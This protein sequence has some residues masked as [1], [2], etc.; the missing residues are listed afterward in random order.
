MQ[1]DND[2]LMKLYEKIL[3]IR[4]FEERVYKLILEGFVLGS[5]HLSIGEEASAVGTISALEKEDYILPTHR[6]HA[7]HL[8]KGADPLRLMAELAGKETGYCGGVSGSIHIFDRENHNLGSNGI[9][10]AQF[11]I[12]IGAGFAIKYKKLNNCVVCF[13]GD[14]ATNQGWFYELLNFA[15]LWSLPVIIVVVN[16]L[17]GM[18][19]PYEKTSLAPISKKPEV[20]KIK[21]DTV[22]GNDVESVYLKMNDIVKYVKKEKKPALLECFTYRWSGHSAHDK[23]PYRSGNE[24]ASWKKRDPVIIARNKLVKRLVSVEMLDSLEKKVIGIINDAEK[25]ARESKFPVFNDEM[26]L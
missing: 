4:N 16:N 19:T 7:Q 13:S 15:S 14:G 5:V 22:D 12:A 21:S 6:G 26:Q 8:A 18:G 17:Y 9:V 3:L 20:F 1:I 25:F 2:F 10:G 23:R 24:I 11:P